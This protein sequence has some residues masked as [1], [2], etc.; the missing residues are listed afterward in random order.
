MRLLLAAI[1]CLTGPGGAQAAWGASTLET[2]TLW[3]FQDHYWSEEWQDWTV[4]EELTPEIGAG[5]WE[6]QG[7]AVFDPTQEDFRD[8]TNPLEL[9]SS[10]DPIHLVNEF[11]GYGLDADNSPPQGTG[12]KTAGVRFNVSTKGFTGIV[13]SFDIRHKYRSPRHAQVQYTVDGSNW[14]DSIVF[15]ANNPY[16][17]DAWFNGRTVDLSDV[18]GAADNPLFA[19]R[20]VAAFGPSGQYE[21]SRAGSVYRQRD[22]FRFDMVRVSGV[23]IREKSYLL[24]NRDAHHDIIAAAKDNF[25]FTVCGRVA[26]M[27]TTGFLL[28]DGSGAPIRI[29]VQDAQGISEGGYA[30]ATGKLDNQNGSVTLQSSAEQVQMLD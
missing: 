2:I 27:D 20:V 9:S 24:S 25:L 7:T 4:E 14:I 18:P 12:N 1:L 10:S 19:F 29:L 16:E 28:D 21:A 17:A 13:I 6:M 30:K 15:E 5:T 22:N 8:P 23:P 11:M 3:D 26:E